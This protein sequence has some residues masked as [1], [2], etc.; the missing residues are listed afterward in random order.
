MP[1]PY[2]EILLNSGLIAGQEGLNMAYGDKMKF[3]LLIGLLGTFSISVFSDDNYNSLISE[4]FNDVSKNQGL[5]DD[6][7]P[8]GVGEF[9]LDKIKGIEFKFSEKIVD[10]KND[11]TGLGLAIKYGRKLE[12]S[13]EQGLW[14]RSD[15]YEVT[16][17]FKPANFMD[18][19]FTFGMERGNRITFVKQYDSQKKAAFKITVDDNI[20]KIPFNSDRVLNRMV[21]GDFFSMRANMNL[22]AGFKGSGSPQP[23]LELSGE[24]LYVL[25][26][27]F[28][29][30]VYRMTD[31]RARIKIFAGDTKGGQVKGEVGVGYQLFSIN[32]S[33]D[34]AETVIEEVLDFEPLEI[35][36]EAKQGSIV[37]F[38]YLFNLKNEEARKAYDGLMTPSLLIKDLKALNALFG[39]N[40]RS[41]I[42]DDGEP[43]LLRPITDEIRAKMDKLL[44][45]MST[46][47]KIANEDVSKKDKRITKV[48][49]AKNDFQEKASS[50]DISLIIFKWEDSKNYLKNN[51]KSINANGEDYFYAPSFS[52]KFEV[53]LGIDDFGLKSERRSS[54][55]SIFNTYPK[56]DDQDQ[57]FIFSDLGTIIRRE[58]NTFSPIEIGNLK[59][60]L[61]YNLPKEEDFNHFKGFGFNDN[62]WFV[63]KLLCW[64]NSVKFNFEFFVNPYGLRF[65]KDNY[66]TIDDFTAAVRRLYTKKDGT[67]F[68]S[69]PF[70]SKPKDSDDYK[71]LYSKTAKLSL[72]LY[73][74]LSKKSNL[75]SSQKVEKLMNY[76]KKYKFRKNL[77]YLVKAFINNESEFAKSTFYEVKLSRQRKEIKPFKRGK[78]TRQ[79]YRQIRAIETA[80][81]DDDSEAYIL[82]KN[83]DG[84]DEIKWTLQ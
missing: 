79:L 9:L 81:Q 37:V 47:I 65:I 38:D 42:R 3:F 75:S 44:S 7:Q 63:L 62:C 40:K 43:S 14:L 11:K 77:P 55:F 15:S 54:F 4:N 66:I 71:R 31:D 5:I 61:K 70:F 28:V 21:P 2:K 53:Q 64:K 76:R 39:S 58:D 18:F 23:G 27:N 46:V 6:D 52:K 19:P 8:S 35:M 17:S 36:Y 80:L 83:S 82:F 73:E 12:Q 49:H 57:N 84:E 32:P 67:T 68:K 41:G 48:F 51:I 33:N 59:E 16:Q 72:E 34:V 60:T 10:V 45:D 50:F 56:V 29:I 69:N 1:Q 13:D 25:T 24:A 26:G 78:D 22:F 30:Q 20:K 74:I